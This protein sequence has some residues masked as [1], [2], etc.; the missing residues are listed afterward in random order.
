[1]ATGFAKIYDDLDRILTR[2][3]AG[4]AVHNKVDRL[5]DKLAYDCA[6][7]VRELYRKAASQGVR[8][9]D[10]ITV[11]K[12]SING[13][14]ATVTAQGDSILFVEFGTGINENYDS[15]SKTAGEYGFSPA[16]WSVSHEKWLV[17]E[18]SIQFKGFWPVKDGDKWGWTEGHPPVDAMYYAFEKM[19]SELEDT[20][21]AIFG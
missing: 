6:R 15:P 5:L 21:R 17:P 7:N 4:G 14:T 1:M 20:E 18:R 13:D 9:A 12:P 11:Q 16:S 8:G 19:C 10:K 2:N 3:T